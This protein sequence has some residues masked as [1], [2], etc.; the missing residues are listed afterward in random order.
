ML[1]AAQRGPRF[2]ISLKRSTQKS[3]AIHKLV[4]RL[5]YL[6]MLWTAPPLLLSAMEVGTIIL[7]EIC[8]AHESLRGPSATSRHLHLMVAAGYKAD[9]HTRPQMISFGGSRRLSSFRFWVAAHENGAST[10][11]LADVPKR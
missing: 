1:E 11:A 3:S 5:P 8:A 2:T 4:G 10:S 6:L 9:V 7:P